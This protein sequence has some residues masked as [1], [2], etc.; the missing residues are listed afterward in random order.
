MKHPLIISFVLLIFS[1]TGQLSLSTGTL[2]RLE[3]YGLPNETK[4]KTYY[5]LTTEYQIKK[6]RISTQFSYLP[7]NFKCE[8]THIDS[9][10]GSTISGYYNT[11]KTT[12]YSADIKYAYFGWLIGG[13]R[14]IYEEGDKF[15][16]SIGL[17]AQIDFLVNEQETNHLTERVDVYTFTS[18]NQFQSSYKTT[19]VQPS[20]SQKFDAIL[21]EKV[22]PSFVLNTGYRYNFTA[23]FI[24]FNLSA[25]LNLSPRATNQLF[26]P[27]SNNERY[28]A[29]GLFNERLYMFLQ[30]GAKIG[31]TF[32]FRERK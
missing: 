4:I 3:G 11:T 25:G 10:S 13:D 8:E 18:N 12:T 32:H 1:A 16:F 14:L 20:S 5:G 7:K 27:Y 23:F 22:Y 26:D 29:Y 24:H 31:H 21:L 30:G 9:Q 6:W 19:T 15:Q 17:Y 2:F 28:L